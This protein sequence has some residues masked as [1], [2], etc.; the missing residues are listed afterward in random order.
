MNKL[1]VILLAFTL[2]GCSQKAPELQGAV[3]KDAI[4]V[5]PNS[6]GGHSPSGA[7]M[8]G[9]DGAFYGRH[10]ELKTTDPDEKVIEFY[11]QAL[12]GATVQKDEDGTTYRW[13]GFPGAEK[14][15]YISV[16]VDKGEIFITE[17]L[18]EGKHK[19]N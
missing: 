19:A 7:H 9:D 2:W 8:S 5:Y 18:K 17:C 14:G 15:E 16:N 12:P 11:K 3:H 1:I 4:P 10:F 13:S 6:Q